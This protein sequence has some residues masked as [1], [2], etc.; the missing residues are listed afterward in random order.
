MYEHILIKKM[1]IFEIKICKYNFTYLFEIL[2]LDDIPLNIL[3]HILFVS[4]PT[5]IIMTFN[6]IFYKIISLLYF[7]Y[8]TLY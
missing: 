7:F 5:E 3:L 4:K 1:L 2:L 6:F 8:I